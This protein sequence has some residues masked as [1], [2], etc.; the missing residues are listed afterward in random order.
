MMINSECFVVVIAV[1]YKETE[2]KLKWK[3]EKERKLVFPE[4]QGFI[5][6][7]EYKNSGA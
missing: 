7:V 2:K 1:L 6:F 4:F 5:Y 3:Q